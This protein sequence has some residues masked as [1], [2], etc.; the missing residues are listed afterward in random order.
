MT[1]KTKIEFAEY[2]KMALTLAF[3]SW[4]VKLVLFIIAFYLISSL[5]GL[6]KLIDYEADPVGN[7]I[8]AIL[9]IIA[10]PYFVLRAIK[11]NFYSN[12]RVSEV[13]EY[14]F[15]DEILS[16]KGESFKSEWRLN[17]LYK[18]L[19][20]KK[21]FLIYHDVRSVSFI[22]KSDLSGEQVT[23]LRYLLENAKR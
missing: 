11:K 15:T 13:L 23:E 6:F 18:F 2:R 19:E 5:A 3:R 1:F 22:S 12:A 16:V 7:L 4:K 8:F 14:T 10:W 21:W 17:K 20:L 9:L